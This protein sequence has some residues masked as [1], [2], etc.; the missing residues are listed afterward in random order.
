M[1]LYKLFDHDFNWKRSGTSVPFM[2]EVPATKNYLPAI[3]STSGGKK[4]GRKFLV[5]DRLHPGDILKVGVFQYSPESIDDIIPEFVRTSFVLSKDMKYDNIY[6]TTKECFDFLRKSSKLETQPHCC[7]IPSTWS[8]AR[9]KTFFGKENLLDIAEDIFV[10][11]KCCR[12][13][14]S[15]V[16]FPVFF[17]KPDYVGMI[18]QF[19][20]GNFAIVSHGIRN[21][22]AFCFEEPIVQKTIKIIKK[23]II[24]K[25]KAVKRKI[26]R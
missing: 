2:I 19:N 9:I 17:S 22:I 4:I 12:I 1:I 15:H 26:V 5:L 13:Y 10:Y 20:G 14:P 25:K 3:I 16:D 23:K 8:S 21:S 6:P 18:A 11:N 24:K 7:L